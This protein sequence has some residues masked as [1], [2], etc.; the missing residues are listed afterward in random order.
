MCAQSKGICTMGSGNA[1]SKF[2]PYQEV[3]V[4]TSSMKTH[5]LFHSMAPGLEQNALNPLLSLVWQCPKQIRQEL[6]RVCSHIHAYILK[7][8]KE[9]GLPRHFSPHQRGTFH[10]L[11]FRF[12]LFIQGV[13]TPYWGKGNA[14]LLVLLRLSFVT[15]SL[16]FQN[17]SVFTFS[18]G[19]KKKL[20]FFETHDCLIEWKT[21]WSP[22][23]SKRQLAT[24]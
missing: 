3:A 14:Q 19:K 21:S 4:L 1:A 23:W 9:L 5:T 7:R 17:S 11:I 12:K 22:T 16:P 6:W 13:I 10:S 2:T 15:P 24:N 20:D 8:L 18:E